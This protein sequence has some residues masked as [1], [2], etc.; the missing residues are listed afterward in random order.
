MAA[1]GRARCPRRRGDAGKRLTMSSRAG[2]F[3]AFLAANGWAGSSPAPLAGDAS[4][5]RYFRLTE[6]ARRAVLMD[7]PPPEQEKL[8]AYVAVAEILRRLRLSAPEIFAADYDAGLLLIEDFGDDS[9]TR[10]LAGGADE[11]ALY[12][13]AIDTLIA[14]Q[15]AI[16]DAGLPDL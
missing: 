4:F 13:L 8:P 2:A 9:F 14:L 5:R 1:R 6:G 16:A 3:D 7:A 11:Q 12:T 15:H 10:C